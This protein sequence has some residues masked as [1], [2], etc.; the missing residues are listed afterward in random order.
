MNDYTME[1]E[2]S[3]ETYLYL[4]QQFIHFNIKNDIQKRDLLSQLKNYA[5][6]FPQDLRILYDMWIKAYPVDKTDIF[7]IKPIPK[8][9]N[10]THTKQIYFWNNPSSS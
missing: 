3:A 10:D 5:Y 4:C 2:C 9:K 8:K 1:R 6:D 7:Q